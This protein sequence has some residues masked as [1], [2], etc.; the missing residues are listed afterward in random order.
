MNRKLLAGFRRAAVQLS[1][2]GLFKSLLDS[3]ER[4]SVREETAKWLAE[5]PKDQLLEI[6]RS[7][8]ASENG[9]ARRLANRVASV[10]GRETPWAEVIG[11]LDNWDHQV[12]EETLRTLDAPE[13]STANA[14]VD[15]YR[16]SGK[17]PKDLLNLLAVHS[18]AGKSRLRESRP[19][20]R[21]ALYR[22]SIHN[23]DE[24]VQS[25]TVEILQDDTIWGE[26]DHE[27]LGMSGENM[28]GFFSAYPF[29][30]TLAYRRPSARLLTLVGVEASERSARRLPEGAQAAVPKEFLQAVKAL[31]DDP[32]GWRRLSQKPY[33][34]RWLEILLEN[35]HDT[36]VMAALDVAAALATDESLVDRIE[37]LGDPNRPERALAAAGA[38]VWLP[39]A[40][41]RA[42]T[43]VENVFHTWTKPWKET[44]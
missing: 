10:L 30:E 19:H 35:E 43:I 7:L 12:R 26:L 27:L 1:Y 9:H 22:L 29:S 34:G 14:F 38:F 31:M 37:A 40:I 39:K 4:P 5:V 20:L 2:P 3:V 21:A 23:S 16:K 13:P 36:V 42:L 6:F 8:R 11:L 32:K 25:G 24:A 15:A 33:P 28:L 18:M 41:P 17:E 44:G